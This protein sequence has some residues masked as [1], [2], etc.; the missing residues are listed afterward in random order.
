LQSLVWDHLMFILN[1]IFVCS[2]LWYMGLIASGYVIFNITWHIVDL[3]MAFRVEHTRSILTKNRKNIKVDADIVYI[4]NKYMPLIKQ[5]NLDINEL[6][7]ANDYL[8]E[9]IDSL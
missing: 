9:Y 6:V 8:S 2:I 5:H 1:S 4:T 7:G 3:G